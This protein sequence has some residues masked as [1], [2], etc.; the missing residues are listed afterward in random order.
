MTAA[1]KDDGL[2]GSD[3]NDLATLVDVAILPVALQTQARLGVD[4]RR[5]VRFDTDYPAGERL[6]ADD[7][8][9]VL[10]EHELDTLLPGGELQWP[11]QRNAVPHGV[12]TD[13]RARVLHLHRGKRA[14]ALGVGDSGILGRDSPRPDVRA[15]AEHEEAVGRP[16]A[17]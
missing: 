8:V 17:R 1:R 10:V 16:G 9:H 2:S 13:E 3:I 11:G 4:P 14:G 5:V 15:V 7:L 6:L 12:G